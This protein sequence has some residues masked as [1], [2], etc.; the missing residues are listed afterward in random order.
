MYS[1]FKSM[2]IQQWIKE[3][4][5]TLGLSILVAELFFKFHSFTLECVGFLCTWFV[6]DWV[7]GFLKRLTRKS[8][9]HPCV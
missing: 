2:S 5:P 8:I 9:K 3:Q 4:L 6:F 7:I 1:L